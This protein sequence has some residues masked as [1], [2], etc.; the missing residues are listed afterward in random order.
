MSNNYEK[1]D[2]ARAAVI[3][4]AKIADVVRYSRL[5]LTIHEM[6]DADLDAKEVRYAA[7][8]VREVETLISACQEEYRPLLLSRTQVGV[9]PR[10]EMEYYAT[11]T[12]YKKRQAACEEFMRYYSNAKL[13]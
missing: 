8:A 9:D 12:Y 1:Y 7:I 3:Q 4:F 11:S 6:E 2:D 10:K 5:T 13:I